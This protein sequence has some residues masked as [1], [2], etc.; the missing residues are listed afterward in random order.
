MIVL[1]IPAILLGW[2]VFALDHAPEGYEDE[3]GFHF[4]HQGKIR[5]QK[6]TR[7][8]PRALTGR[9]DLDGTELHQRTLP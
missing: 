1:L 8:V 4:G 7:T 5:S 9:T 3:N 6:G 2:L